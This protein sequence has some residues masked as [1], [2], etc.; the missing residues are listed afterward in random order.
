MN[1]REQ[2][3]ICAIARNRSITRAAR[4]LNITQAALSIY[5]QN[6]EKKLGV[7][8]FDRYK[9]DITPTEIGRLYIE[10]AQRILAEGAFFDERLKDYLENGRGHIR[11]GI[12][13]RRS[14]MIV[15]ELLMRMRGLYPNVEITVRESDTLS[16]TGLISSHEL[17]CTCS[18][19][20]LSGFGLISEKIGEDRLGLILRSDLPV[21]SK[22]SEDPED[23]Q[24]RLDIRDLEDE[25]FLIYENDETRNAFDRM[26]QQAGLRLRVEEYYNVE[27]MLALADRGYGILYMN[28][29]YMHHWRQD[30]KDSRLRFVSVK[31]Q[32]ETISVYLSY[33]EHLVVSEYG[34]D[35][36]KMVREAAV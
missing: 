34:R 5:I 27:T 15:P 17:D 32:E 10:S 9:R 3:Y 28:D 31:G 14:P 6:L 35:F 19:Q 21:C 18:Y 4:E 20:D 24:G 25:T 8:L 2:E 22:I 12:N 1:L 36:M 13:S 7:T 33:H 26:Q 16:L 29:V 23:G 11:F 30:K